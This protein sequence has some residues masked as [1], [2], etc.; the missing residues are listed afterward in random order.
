MSIGCGEML[1]ERH[2]LL[3]EGVSCGR[4]RGGLRIQNTYRGSWN[5]LMVSGT[6]GKRSQASGSV[7]PLFCTFHRAALILLFALQFQLRLRLPLFV[8]LCHAW[9]MDESL[10]AVNDANWVTSAA[11]VTEGH[12]QGLAAVHMRRGRSRLPTTYPKFCR[13]HDGDSR[14]CI[15]RA[16]KA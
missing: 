5:V 10:C 7:Y 14:L 8:S 2:Y 11:L 13:I 12:L 4:H 16:M 1:R 9:G 6:W 15:F 3:R